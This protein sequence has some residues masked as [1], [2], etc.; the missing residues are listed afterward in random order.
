M[1]MSNLRFLFVLLLSL[2]CRTT[3]AAQQQA[4]CSSS[5]SSGVVQART[6]ATTVP[7]GGGWLF[8]W[9]K[10]EDRY[11]QQLED[12]IENL[13]RQVRAAREE[14]TQLRKLLKLAS[15]TNTRNKGSASSATDS[16]KQEISLL[17]KQVTQLENFQREL[18]ALLVKEQQRT[19][20]L[21][22]KLGESEENLLEVHNQHLLELEKLEQVLLQKSKQSLDDL[23]T[24]MIQR[25]QEAADHARKEA[26]M[27][28]DQKIATA[29][30]KVEKKA[31]AELEEERKKAADAVEKERVK[32]RKLVKALA[33]REKKAAKASSTVAAKKNVVSSSTSSRKQPA[34]PSTVRSPLNK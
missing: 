22:K 16:I 11:R 15:H 14:S 5:S 34:N 3:F 17:H 1:T 13:D 30:S 32:M 8:S 19:Q 18:E 20:E 7:R 26:L 25:V 27:D 29:V 31:R 6:M 23:N 24:L 10:A 2:A 4:S 9:T 33:E 12:Q 28:V 21:E